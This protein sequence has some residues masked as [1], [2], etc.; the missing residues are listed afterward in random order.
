MQEFILMLRLLLKILGIEQNKLESNLKKYEANRKV[1]C[2]KKNR[3][4]VKN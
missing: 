2:N 1:H 4:R 3:R